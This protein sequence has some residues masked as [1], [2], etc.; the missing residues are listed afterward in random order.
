MKRG[1]GASFMPGAYVFAGGAVDSSDASD[2]TYALSPDFTDEQASRRLNVPVHGLSYYVA[3]AREA[4]E[5]CGLLMAYRAERAAEGRAA[6]DGQ[7]AH[8][9]RPALVELT[10]WEE[11]QLHA[12]RNQVSRQEIDFAQLCGAHGWRLAL[13]ELHYFAH[14][15]TPPEMKQRFDTRFFLC[16]APEHQHASLASGEMSELLWCS[17]AAALDACAAGKLRLMFATRE[18]LKQIGDFARIESLLEYARQPRD[19]TTVIPV[20]P[21][22]SLP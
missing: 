13:A 8:D 2:A 7:G 3:A 21:P 15:I 18:M 20:F 12:L 16:R 5:E 4:F 6:N 17:A 22:A 9:G 11:A 14:W 1:A 19:I 10:S